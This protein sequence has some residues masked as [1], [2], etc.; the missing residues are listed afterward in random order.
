[1]TDRSISTKTRDPQ[2]PSTSIPSPVTC[3]ATATSPKRTPKAKFD[4]NCC[5]HPST[6]SEVV[7][8]PH[9][10]SDPVPTDSSELTALS[11]ITTSVASSSDTSL[12]E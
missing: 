9:F 5:I 7:I 2:P 12:P 4:R 6:S 8:E 10:D 3:L 11:V 1:M